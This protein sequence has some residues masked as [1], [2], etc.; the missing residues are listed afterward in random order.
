M[1]KLV[2]EGNKKETPLTVKLRMLF[3]LIQIYVNGNSNLVFFYFNNIQE[4]K[5][6]W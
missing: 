5:L 6:T 2:P 4:M 1:F 3:I